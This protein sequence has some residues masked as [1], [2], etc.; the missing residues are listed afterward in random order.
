MQALKKMYDQP[1]ARNKVSFMTH[2]SEF[3]TIVDQLASVAITF[4]DE[5][6][7]FL[8]MSQVPKSWHGTITVVSN[9]TE[10]EKLKLSEVVNLILTEDVR[11]GS[12]DHSGSGTSGSALSFEQQKG[13]IQNVRH[14]PNLKRN[15]VSVGQLAA[16][17]YT[18]TFTGDTWR[19]SKD[20]MVAAKGKKVGTLYLTS[21]GSDT[22]VVLVLDRRES[23][24][25][26]HNRLGHM[27]EKRMKV[28]QAIGKLPELDDH[29]MEK[30]DAKSQKCTFIEN[31]EDE[32]GYCFLDDKNTKLAQLPA[33]KK[34]LLNKWVYRLKQE[35]D[36]K[37]RYKGRLVVKGFQQKE[38]IDYTEIF[39]LVVKIATMRMMLCLVA[40]ENLYLEQFDVKTAFLHGDLDEEIYMKQPVGFI[41]KGKEEIVCML[42][43]SLYGLKQALRQWVIEFDDFMLAHPWK[44]LQ[45][46]LGQ[47][48]KTDAE[49]EREY[50]AKVSY[51]SHMD[52]LM[53]A[54]VHTRPDIA[55]V[56][57]VVSKFASNPGKQHL[58]AVKWI[59]RY[60]RGRTDLLLCIV[61]G[62]LTLKVYVDADFAYD[63][64][65]GYVYTMGATT[66]S[67]VSRLQK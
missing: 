55:H 21:H 30:L 45:T 54:M 65:T 5:V 51:T 56:V 41:V 26:W 38:G 28:M 61:R 49:R 47:S 14:D 32:F 19:V 10:K 24:N 17:G 36:G 9:S 4:D 67:W 11:R 43:K 50:M 60:L 35:S 18:S 22:L 62:K 46:F 37:K 31:G 52:S 40:A 63:H 15:L 66:M 23:S 34:A 25:L 1:S 57:G 33:G 59:M 44:S 16:A 6:Q 3:N 29:D 64:G 39:L 12:I 48:L 53:Y 13:K 8:I 7:A 2:L 27:S 42:K 58:E 20:T